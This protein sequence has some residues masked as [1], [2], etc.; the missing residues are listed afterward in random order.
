MILSEPAVG[1]T[2][3]K[4]LHGFFR[5]AHE[6]EKDRFGVPVDATSQQ[7]VGVIYLNPSEQCRG[8][9]SFFRHKGMGIDRT[10]MTD[11]ELHAYGATSI[12]LENSRL[13]Q[14]V[15]FATQGQT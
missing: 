5:I 13:I 11:E 9:T 15:S 6:G 1:A 10:P 14:L 3:P 4:S 12:T 8:G 2:D 7:W